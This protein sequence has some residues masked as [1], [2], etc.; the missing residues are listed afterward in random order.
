MLS[1]CGFSTCASISGHSHWCSRKANAA[2]AARASAVHA[3]AE[4]HPA[5]RDAVDATDQAFVVIDLDAVCV[6]QTM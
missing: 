5:D 1:R 4:E 2:S 6:A 3:F